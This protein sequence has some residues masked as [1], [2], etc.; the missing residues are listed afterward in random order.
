[1]ATISKLYGLQMIITRLTKPIGDGDAFASV[2]NGQ[3]QI[4]AT[5][6]INISRRQP[7][8]KHQLVNMA[9]IF[10]VAS[11]VIS[12]VYIIDGVMPVTPTK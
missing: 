6:D 12:I 11:I 3:Y 10:S 2:F 7:R 5:T 1:M 4:S 9:G 8:F